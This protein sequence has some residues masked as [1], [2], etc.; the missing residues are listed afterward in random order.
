[1][2]EAHITA[3]I[4]ITNKEM[5]QA[6]QDILANPNKTI[7]LGKEVLSIQE[8]YIDEVI[9]ISVMT[10][11]YQNYEKDFLKW[12]KKFDVKLAVIIIEGDQS[13]DYIGLQGNKKSSYKKTLSSLMKLSKRIETGIAMAESDKKILEY[14]K[15]NNVDPY[16][17][18]QGVKHVDRIISVGKLAS[19][20]YFVDNGLNPNHHYKEYRVIEPYDEHMLFGLDTY[21]ENVDADRLIKNLVER[22]A[23]INSVDCH[24]N[25]M[26]HNQN[27][28][29]SE[30][31]TYLVEGGI[32]LS[33]K[34]N[35]GRTALLEIVKYFFHGDGNINKHGEIKLI[36]LIGF[37]VRSGANPAE[38]DDDGAGLLIYAR[39]A[40]KTKKW[41]LKNHPDLPLHGPDKDYEQAVACQFECKSYY[42]QHVKEG[43]LSIFKTEKF[44][45]WLFPQENSNASVEAAFF[46]GKGLLR[47]ACI[48]DCLE[49]LKLLESYGFP[50]LLG[51]GDKR[52]TLLLARENQSKEV[53]AYMESKGLDFALISSAQTRFSQWYN[54]SKELLEQGLNISLD[55]FASPKWQEDMRAYHSSPSCY[56]REGYNVDEYLLMRLGNHF[57][58]RIPLERI[59]DNFLG[60]HIFTN[61]SGAYMLEQAEGYI[62]ITKHEAFEK[63]QLFSK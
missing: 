53:L 46:K 62:G 16:E 50:L 54:K 13:T 47:S 18:Y 1:M 56:G 49:V 40:H 37:L 19:L 31:V 60:E 3:E 36:K 59:L 11:G 48:H 51:M 26:L 57:Q 61:N 33:L 14:I 5:H 15:K 2:S 10:G 38:L 41:L 17:S 45:L 58:R 9:F 23:N 12:L 34:N 52:H 32:N 28:Y 22:G 21:D 42:R 44:K 43:M 39:N 8:S 30:L 29:S 27:C 4:Y 55:D 63:M 35:K 20:K 6:L 24:C 7:S 25:T